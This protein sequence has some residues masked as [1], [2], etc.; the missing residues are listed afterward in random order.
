MNKESDEYGIYVSILCNNITFHYNAFIDNVLVIGIA[1]AYD[2]STNS[3]W[4]DVTTNEGNFWNDTVEVV[5]ILL[6][7]E[8]SLI[9]IL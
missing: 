9:S 6:T 2:D 4:Y 1:Q 3:T 7:V 8:N 5:T